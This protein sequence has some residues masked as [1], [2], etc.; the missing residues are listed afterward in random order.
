MSTIMK[1]FQENEIALKRFIKRFT[2]AS[3]NVDDFAQE[4]FLKGFAAELR[5]QINDPK[6]FLFKIAKN[7][8]LTEVRKDARSPRGY[9]KNVDDISQILDEDQAT[10]E[11][12]LDGRK[13]L[14]LFSKAV[15]QLTPRCREAFLMRRIDNLQYKQIANRMDISV[16]AV[17]K[18]VT[19]GL[20]KCNKYLR[21]Q[22]YQPSE[23]GAAINVVQGIPKSEYKKMVKCDE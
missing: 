2:S 12:W 7:V 13:K 9:I 18:H 17:E 20:L 4:T 14:I 8:A 3:H 16:S 23:F 21:A 19:T 11:D 6:A 5:M 1:V 22:G 10:A 15:A